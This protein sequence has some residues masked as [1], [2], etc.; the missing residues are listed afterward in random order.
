LNKPFPPQ[1]HEWTTHGVCAGCADSVD[2]FTQVCAL[3]GPPL[4]IMNDSKASGG[5]LNA[6]V[7]ALTKAG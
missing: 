3:S 7:A 6:M 1:Q 2:F 5:D 4:A